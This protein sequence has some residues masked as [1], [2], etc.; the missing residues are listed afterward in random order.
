MQMLLRIFKY[1]LAILA[2]LL[3]ILLLVLFTPPLFR[4][5]V[6]YPRI[7]RETT[8]F[9]KLRKEPVPVTKL[10]VFRGVLHVHSFWSHDS[11]GILADIIP[12]AKSDGIDFI[13]L[14]D[15]P[16]GNIDTLPRGYN[17]SFEN[18][19]VVPGSEKQGFDA[20]PLDS[21]VIDWSQDKD[22]ISKNIVKNGGIIFY[23]HPE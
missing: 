5:I 20:W 3:L 6:T 14:T 2:G 23:A 22:T 18:V 11:E 10:K 7:E 13:F 19:L 15:H 1:I 8:E 12:A 21:V 16:H 17:G 9:Q 4:H